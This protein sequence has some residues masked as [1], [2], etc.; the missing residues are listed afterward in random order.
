[1][2]KLKLLLAACALLLGAGQTWAQTDVTS[3]Y[4]TNAG[5]EG[6]YSV[7]SN[8]QSG[9]AIYQPTGWGVSYSNGEANDMT[10]LNSEC[11]QW[12]NFSNRP[13]PVNGG[14]N[15]YW[16]RFR[17]G[18]SE[19]LTLSQT[20]TLP[21]GTYVFSADA[22]FNGADGGT[23][24]ISANSNS[25]T[26][27]G[28]SSWKNYPVL[29]TLSD[30]TSVT[31]SFNLTQ[32]KQV[33]NIAGFDNFK[34]FSLANEDEA[35]D[36]YLIEQNNLSEATYANPVATNFVINGTFDGSNISMWSCNTAFKNKDRK[37]TNDNN[38]GTMNDSKPWWEN[39]NGS[40]LVNKMYQVIENV[41]NG[42]YRLDITAF[43][44]N[45][46]AESQYVFANNDHTALTEDAK[47]GAAYEVYTV[48][49]NNRIE[50]GLEQTT[51]TANWMGIDNVSLRYYGPGNV[52]ND[53]K[54]AAHKLAWLE[55][56]AAAEAAL[57]NTAYA[58]V[59]GSEKTALQT[60]VGKTEPTTADGYDAAAA[61]LTSATAAFIAAAPAYDALKAEIAYAKTIGVD[62]ETAEA[63]QNTEATAATITAA[64]QDLKVLEY[65]TITNGYKNDVSG[66]LGTWNAG[67]YE[68]PKSGEG[69]RSTS[70][71]YFDKWNGSAMDLTSSNAATLP[72]GKYTV[73]VAGRGVSTT[74]M[75]LSVK[76]GEAEAVSTPFLLI[77]NTGKGIDTNG[78]TNFSD[79]GTYSNNNNGRGW[80]Y[81]YIT[82]ET[83]GT[84]EVT[85]AIN[86]HLNASTWQG[87][88]APV[89]LCDDDTYAPIAVDAAK[90][91]LQAAIDAA[92]AVPEENV[93]TAAFQIPS[94]GVA[95]YSEA[96][97]AAQAAHDAANATVESIE[98]AKTDLAAAIQAFNA[99]EINAPADGQL[100]TVSLASG[101]WAANN[102][103][104]SN[105]AMTY[106][107]NGRTDAGNYNIQY[108]LAANKNLAQAFTFTKVEGNKYKMSQIDADGVARYISTG[109]PYKGNTAQIRTTTEADKALVVEVI[110]TNEEAIWN[111][112]NTEANNYIGAQDAGVYTVNSHIKFA[113]AETQKPTITVGAA[114]DGGYATTMVP[115][116]VATLPNGLKAYRCAEVAENV[117]TLEEVN[118]LEA[119]KPYIVEGTAAKVTGDAQGTELTYKEGLLTGVY[120]ETP[121]TKGSYVLQKL[122]DVIGF[123]QVAEGKQPTIGANHAYLTVASQS[124]GVR[125]FF[126]PGTTTGISA[127]QMLLDGN[128]EIYDMNGVRTQQL[129]KGMN[130]IRMQDGTTRK[131]MVK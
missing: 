126:F 47:T 77:G 88:Y 69:Y 6:E 59:I 116:A 106:I 65:T 127:L 56:K 24:K 96:I 35:Y 76:V 10:S 20:V 98:Q 68:Y 28:T 31:L 49:T 27:S 18:N 94:A 128:S 110:P 109:V 1:M 67:S 111:L 13:Q 44:N 55:A 61:A 130:I 107:A 34:L 42:T 32:T 46:N 91:E 81:R 70:E 40:A 7:Y 80:Q 103:N 92:P 73:M 105:E 85:I 120:A 41:P 100:F 95:T 37:T 90:A 9:R 53:A 104:F 60:E 122:N 113:I 12:S 119:N 57:N 2:R 108:K 22:F 5:F 23:A 17:W 131:I 43:V 19:S 66:L 97:K 79:E 33:E 62:T 114:D 117:L 74:T 63:A 54:N 52:I 26:I 64:T 86:G 38:A 58:N 14:N 118:A 115:F 99:L 71:S 89:L 39:W 8:P 93:G 129:K 84:A 82:F 3:T 15:T 125:A 102:V 16:I 45:F 21:A 123:Y 72:A 50:V 75:S 83:D 25:T 101:E 48:V 29:F 121:A 4:L 36:E 87:F 11:L 124:A 51:A 78:A 30:E 112:R